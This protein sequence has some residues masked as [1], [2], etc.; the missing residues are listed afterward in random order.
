[1]RWT[2]VVQRGQL[3]SDLGVGMESLS[4][5]CEWLPLLFLA[6]LGAAELVAAV[7]ELGTA[8]VA[9]PASAVPVGAGR[10]GPCSSCA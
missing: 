7:V 2:L 4:L 9:W 10:P 8:I 3:Q 1:M 5:T 6:V